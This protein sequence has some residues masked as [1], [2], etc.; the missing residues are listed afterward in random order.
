[1]KIKMT[2]FHKA[3]V[4]NFQFSLPILCA[5]SIFLFVILSAQSSPAQS[6]H[7]VKWVVDGDTI[8]LNTGQRIRYLGI[9]APEIDHE[10]SKAQPYGYQARS[11][12]KKLLIS[13]KI[14]L[15]FDAE[16]CDQYGRMLAYIF[17]PDGAF[18]NLLLL[19]N[20]LAFYL[21][22]LP[23]VKYEKILCQAQ[24]AAMASRK[25][26]WRNWKKETNGSYIGNP[27]SRRFHRAACPYARKIKS[28]NRILFSS[29]WDAFQAGY[30][31]A[32]ECIAQFWSYKK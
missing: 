7:T 29:K 18:A 8:V 17:L 22:R 32:K 13:R 28:K 21:Y 1:M 15:E 19:E 14:R 20:G 11:F 6:W 2:E 30:A 10:D 23:N 3:S 9:N 26:L 27:R 16:R 12:N 25:G 4:F 5:F 24:L 31:P